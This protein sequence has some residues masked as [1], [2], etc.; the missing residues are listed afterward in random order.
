MWGLSSITTFGNYSKKCSSFLGAGVTSEPH[1]NYPLRIFIT[2]CSDWFLFSPFSINL[3]SDVQ[4]M[5][6]KE[7]IKK[8]PS[9]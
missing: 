2:P 8:P 4:F 3:E 9:C 5:K 6:R 1:V 7:R